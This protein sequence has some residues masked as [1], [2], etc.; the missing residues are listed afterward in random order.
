[1]AILIGRR[2]GQLAAVL[3]IVSFLTFLMLHLMPEDSASAILGQN[4]TDEQVAAI[5]QQLGLDQPLVQ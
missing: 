3:L 1:M 2:L 4:A 5:H